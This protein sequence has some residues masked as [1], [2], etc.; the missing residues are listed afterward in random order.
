MVDAVTFIIAA[1]IIGAII[2][3]LTSKKYNKPVQVFILFSQ[4]SLIIQL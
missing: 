2:G 1:F 3:W 4:N